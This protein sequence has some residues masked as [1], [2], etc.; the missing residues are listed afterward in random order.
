MTAINFP[1][2]LSGTFHTTVLFSVSAQAPNSA[3]TAQSVASTVHLNPMQ[4]INV[5]TSHTRHIQGIQPAPVSAQ[6]MQPAPFSTQGIQATPIGTQGIQP[7]PMSSQGIHPAGSITTQGVQTSSVSSQLVSS[8]AKP[9][10]NISY[11]Q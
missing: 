9:P 2:N 4:L 8:D 5:D 7:P 6:G 1:V 3:I 10:G 11:L